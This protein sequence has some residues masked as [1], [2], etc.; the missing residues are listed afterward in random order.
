MTRLN[1]IFFGELCPSGAHS[2]KLSGSSTLGEMVPRRR[3]E[4]TKFSFV[5]SGC[6]S[7]GI[8]NTALMKSMR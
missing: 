1:S 8:D 6:M 3:A 4:K 5:F 7:H 2:N